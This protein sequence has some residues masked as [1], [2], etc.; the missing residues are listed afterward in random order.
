MTLKQLRDLLDVRR[1]LEN[2]CVER[3]ALRITE[4]QIRELRTVQATNGVE[5]LD[6]YDRYLEE[7]RRFHYLIARASGNRELAELVG[8][9]HDKL[10]RFM[11]IPHFENTQVVTYKNVIDALEMHDVEAARRTLL[12]DIDRTH[13]AILDSVIDDEDRS[14]HI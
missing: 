12:E 5:N 3:A 2:S 9:I 13:D 6:S 14:W 10:A 8:Q 11:L 1:I 4:E 7:N